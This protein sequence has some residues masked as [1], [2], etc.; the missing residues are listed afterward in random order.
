MSKNPCALLT[1]SFDPSAILEKAKQELKQINDI[2]SAPN[3]EPPISHWEV[4]LRNIEDAFGNSS[5]TIRI[6]HFAGHASPGLMQ[7]NRNGEPFFIFSQHLA[8]YI[9]TFNKDLK[10]V[11]LNGCSTQA[12][13]EYFL[14]NGVSAV[15][16]TRKPIGDLYAFKFAKRFYEEFVKNNFPLEQ[17]FSKAHLSLNTSDDSLYEDQSQRRIKDKFLLEKPLLDKFRAANLEVDSDDSLEI[18]KLHTQT[19]TDFVRQETFTDWFPTSHSSGLTVGRATHFSELD[20]GKKDELAYLG[21][22]RLEPIEAI[23]EMVI[24]KTASLCQVVEP[25]FFIICAAE[26]HCPQLLPARFQRFSLSEL[27]KKQ[28]IQLN[29]AQLA[30]CMT[31]L[32]LPKPGKSPRPGSPGERGDFVLDEQ[33]GHFDDH[34]KIVLADIFRQKFGGTSPGN[35]TLGKI[36]RSPRPLL[37]IRHVL[38]HSQWRSPDHQTKLAALLRYY[39]GTYANDLQAQLTERLI[40]IFDLELIVGDPALQQDLFPK[41]A[42]EFKGRLQVFTELHDLDW[43]HVKI[44]ERDFLG[45]ANNSFLN[46]GKIFTVNEEIQDTLPFKELIPSLA[47]EIKR[48]N[49]KIEHGRR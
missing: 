16:A 32:P 21:C 49:L 41:L 34:F 10:L 15:I 45:I 33:T 12:Q 28:Q 19:P 6:F 17:A 23:H 2:F 1:Y 40:V 24:K 43:E 30:D 4:S 14:Q 37:V 47:D 7:T 22:D 13:A 8:K 3:L 20:L 39:I 48:Y 31:E 25:Q 46:V 36:E 38:Q 44:W 11:F 5:K 29:S 42:A 9:G 27:F 18:Y 26:A 35:N